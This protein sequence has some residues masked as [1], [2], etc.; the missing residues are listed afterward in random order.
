MDG[1]SILYKLLLTQNG[2]RVTAKEETAQHLPAFC[3]ERHI[4][5]D[6]TFCL[7]YPGVTRLDVVDAVS[8]REWLGTV[9]KYLKLQERARI[10][11][12][13]PN[14]DVWAHGNAAHHQLRAQTAAAAIN[15]QIASALADNRLQ[16]KHE[17]SKGQP[18]LELWIDGTRLYS[19]WESAERVI[20][21]KQRCFCGNSGLRVTKRLRGCADHAKQA[22]ELA[23]AL[24]DWEKAEEQF[25]KNMQ[26]VRCCG[27]CD[28]CPLPRPQ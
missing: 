1:R 15:D 16:L 13:W 14:N 28:S 17:S 12:G 5:P 22:S 4:N 24:R 10:Q 25:W 9:F 26:D 8:A 21:L 7:Y 23:L 3:P 6:G 20:N 11:R 18:I 19:V 27:T 2:E